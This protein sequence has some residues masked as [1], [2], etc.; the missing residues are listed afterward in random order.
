MGRLPLTKNVLSFLILFFLIFPG[1]L[2]FSPLDG[3]SIHR[4][5]RTKDVPFIEVFWKT[6][7]PS[8]PNKHRFL[9]HASFESWAIFGRFNLPNLLKHQLPPIIHYRYEPEKTVTR[10]RLNR[11]LNQLVNEVGEEVSRQREIGNF[12]ILKDNDFNFKRHCGILIAKHKTYPFVVKL[13]RETPDTLVRPFS[14]G[15]IPCLFFDVAGG[16]SRFFMGGTRIPNAEA[17]KARIAQSPYWS[18][19]LTVPRKW[20]WMPEHGDEMTVVGHRMGPEQTQSADYPSVYCIVCDAIKSE[21][22]LTIAHSSDRAVANELTN[23]IGNRIDPNISNYLV[24]EGTGKIALIDTEHFASI[25]G[26]TEELK[27]KSYGTWYVSLANHYFEKVIWRNK[28][29][30]INDR[31]KPLPETLR[32]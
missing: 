21:R 15:I 27:F 8:R 4:L 5:Q 2:H 28:Q 13:F 24:E 29:E 26:L 31:R 18:N 25:V 20:F 17:I 14:K 9:Y 23:F 1:V 32:V 30:R 12:I 11:E 19:R 6:D 10:E 22:T 16:G 3:R 7:D